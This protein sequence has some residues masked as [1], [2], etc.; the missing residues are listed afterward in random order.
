MIQERIRKLNQYE[1]KEGPVLYWMNRDMRVHDNWALLFAEHISQ[2]SEAPLLVLYNLDPEF[3]GGGRRQTDFKI[4]GLKEIETELQKLTIPFFLVC[5]NNTEDDIITFCDKHNIGAL[6][7]DLFPLKVPKSWLEKIKKKVKIPLY[8]VDAHNII[9][10]WTASPKQEFGAYTIR[11]KIHKLLPR[12]LDE[13]PKL[14][15]QKIEYTY[16]KINWDKVEKSIKTDENIQPVDWITSGQK[17]AMRRLKTFI[18]DI[19]PN[20]SEQRNDPNKDVLSNLSP[21]LHY[22]QISAQR[23]A[24]E[25]S[26]SLAPENAKETFLEELIVRRELSDNYC[27]YNEHYDSFEGFPN[28][29]KITHEKHREDRREFLYT[30]KEFEEGKTHEALWNA[31]QL[32]MVKTGKMHGYMRMYWAKKILEWTKDIETAQK[33]A[34]YLNDKYELDGRDPNGYVGIAWALG[35]LHD[36]AWVERDIFG[37]IRYMNENGS[38]RKFD[39]DKYI[40]TWL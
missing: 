25:V 32:Q 14:Q 35:G 33:I 36:R 28:W 9:P 16:E 27:Y 23:I 11:P 1:Y 6:V 30:K 40:D 8:Q 29:A 4:Q 24:L 21:Y 22:G 18:K 12:F 26:N 3:L 38:R 13:F 39:V 34:I 7:T 17:A 19:L 37:Q 15:K 10:V 2:R 20:Y 5:G 31:C